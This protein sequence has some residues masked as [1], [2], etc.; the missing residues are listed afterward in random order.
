MRGIAFISKNAG[1]R[2]IGNHDTQTVRQMFHLSLL[3]VEVS[4]HI[5]W[6]ATMSEI[7]NARSPALRQN[8]LAAPQEGIHLFSGK[9][10][11]AS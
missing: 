8:R 3:F 6:L 9:M 5:Q 10:K 2:S 7:K 1:V 11:Q 4:F